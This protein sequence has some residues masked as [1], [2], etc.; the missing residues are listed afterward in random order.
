MRPDVAAFH[1]PATGTWSYVVADPATRAA[2]ILDPVLDFDAKSARTSHASAQALL[3]HVRANDLKVEWLLETHAHAD[4]L[5]AAQ[6]LR[7]RLPGATV[8]IGQGIRQTQRSFAPVFGFGDEVPSDGSQF[9]HL[10]E[11]DDR[12]RLGEIDVQVIAAPGHTADCV[13][14][15]VGDALFCGDTLFMPDAGTAR[16]D[17]PNADAAMLWR[18]IQRFYALP[19]STRVFVCHDYGPNGRAVACETTIGEQKRGNVHVRDDTSEA[20]YVA[21]RQARDATLPMPALILQSLQ[22]N[23]RAGALPPADADGTRYL[24][25]PLDR[26]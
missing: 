26:I 19:D 5:S 13:A 22:V 14:Y 6:W 10:F 3:D 16:T 21:L 25:I 9:D 23:L 17:F 2:A 7:E 11:A 18:T 4:H 8:A 12:F 15:L 1:D 24:R 20:E